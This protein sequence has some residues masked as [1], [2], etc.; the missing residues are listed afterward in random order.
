MRH[1]LL[2]VLA[3]TAAACAKA[4]TTPLG[5]IAKLNSLEEVM[6]NQ[7]T[8]ADPQ[9][10]KIDQASFSDAELAALAET[11][12]RVQATSAKTK[13]FSKGR[14]DPAGFEA[15]AAKL[16][17]KSK[18]LAAAVTAKDAKAISAALTDMRGACRECHSKFR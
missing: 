10:K 7:A 9:F 6:D 12:E 1:S 15:V 13:D 14:K 4:M 2:L 18:S 17:D 8:S 16:N 3:L 11:A 5:D